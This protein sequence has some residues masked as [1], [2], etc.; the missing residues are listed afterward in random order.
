M[1][2]E[3]DDARLV[4]IE[5]A[6]VG[7]PGTEARGLVGDVKALTDTVKDNATAAAESRKLIHRRIDAVDRKATRAT[8]WS[9][10]PTFVLVGMGAIGGAWKMLIDK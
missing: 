2:T 10:L 7:I 5:T 9:K 3:S 1:P 6:L 8:W 4:R